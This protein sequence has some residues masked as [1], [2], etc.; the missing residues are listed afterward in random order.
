MT[1]VTSNKPAQSIKYRVHN[2]YVLPYT[3]Q[4]GSIADVVPAGYYKV[5]QA[6]FGYFL[7][8]VS[9]SIKI[10]SV[11]FGSTNGRKDRIF[12]A[13]DETTGSM[14]VGLFGDKGAGKSL[15]ASVVANESIKRGLPVIDVSDSFTTDPSYLEFLNN[16]STC[17]ILFDEF[18][19]H[20]SKLKPSS[21]EYSDKADV[22]KDRQDE[23]LNFFQGT[24][25]SKRLIMLIDNSTSFLSDFLQN[26]PGRM[27][28]YFTYSGVE[29]AVVE[30]LGAHHG[31]P[32]ERIQ[33]CCVYARRFRVS[34]DVINEVIREWVRYPN[35]TLESITAVMNVPTLAPE[36]ETK[37][38]VIS[39][40]AKGES[41]GVTVSTGMCN[42]TSSGRVAVPVLVPNY[43]DL[44]TAP[45]LTE[46]EFRSSSYNE[47][48]SWEIFKEL[49]GKPTRK[50]TY[51]FRDE[52]L[53]GINGLRAAY[54]SG[55]ITV[56][57]ESL[58]SEVNN[59]SEGW[60]NAL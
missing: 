6:P 53:V 47:D 45:E 40:V 26:R 22:A 52:H 5:R 55:D 19:K 33:A 56:V 34:F 50:D 9:D 38:K 48:Y 35:E 39:F 28:Y 16:I 37:G 2:Q 15:L 36:I 18:L 59:R 23:M 12:E 17:T 13:F 24:N 60:T 20:L 27:R 51:I 58:V 54:E 10:P 44:L 1:N 29:Q 8:R 49:R 21:D 31:L 42:I 43:L 7:E 4:E 32:E 30:A 46:E 25:N 14:G 41:A 3:H 11:I 57:I